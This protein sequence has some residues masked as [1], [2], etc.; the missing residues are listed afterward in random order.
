MKKPR[1]KKPRKK[2]PR[3]SVGHEFSEGSRQLWLHMEAAGMSIEAL[4]HRVGFGRG[5]LNRHLYGDQRPDLESA[6]RI[7]DHTGV[8]P[9]LFLVKPCEPFVLPGCRPQKAA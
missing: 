8:E 5:V 2:K 7:L 6:F 3:M 4:R 9:R 1:K